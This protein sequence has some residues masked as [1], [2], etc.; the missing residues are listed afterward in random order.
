MIVSHKYRFIFIKTNKTAGTSIEIALSRFCGKR[1]IITKNFPE[2]EALKQEL[3]YAGPR[4]YCIPFYLY[5]VR[6]WS[7]VINKIKRG[8]KRIKKRFYSHSSASEIRQLV[9][10]GV[11]NNYYKFCFERNP[12]DR[13]ISY[14][15]FI[16]NE[17]RRR[18]KS[19]PPLPEFIDGGKLLPLKKHGIENYTIDGRIAVDRVCLYENMEQELETVCNR[20]L[21][22]PEKLVLPRAKG[23]F[24]TDRRHYREILSDEDRKKIAEMFA[25]EISLF[26]Y[27]F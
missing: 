25:D 13:V 15:Y 1:D 10:E 20:Q 11:W 6:D 9:G 4:N 5:S 21:G 24:R 14:Y 23:N 27:E 19:T 7:E 3:G 16:L 8:E 26:G 18:G 2:E 12:W 22:L 17:R